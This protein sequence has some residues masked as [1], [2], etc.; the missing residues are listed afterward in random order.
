[1]YIHTYV[2]AYVNGLIMRNALEQSLNQDCDNYPVSRNNG[3]M[4]Q[5]EVIK[6]LCNNRDSWAGLVMRNIIYDAVSFL[7]ITVHMFNS[8]VCQ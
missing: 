1:M 2:H 3:P 7:H 5:S 8:I 4:V 6:T